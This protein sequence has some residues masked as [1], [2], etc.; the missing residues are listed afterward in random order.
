[1]YSFPFKFSPSL[2]FLYFCKLLFV[3]FISLFSFNSGTFIFNLQ[4]AIYNLIIIYILF[5]LALNS[6]SFYHLPKNRCRILVNCF[7]SLL[8][9]YSH[10]IRKKKIYGLKTFCAFFKRTEL[11]PDPI[12]FLTIIF[13]FWYLLKFQIKFK[14]KLD[15]T[16]K[17]MSHNIESHQTM[18]Y[19]I[20]ILHL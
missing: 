2:V 10:Q 13:L 9:S 5:F 12:A 18:F 6:K 14:S 15:I 4:Y 20:A 16:I 17:Q 11:V 19:K 8:A 3:I 1:M 7:W